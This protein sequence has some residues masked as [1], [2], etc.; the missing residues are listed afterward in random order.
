MESR[1]IGPNCLGILDTHSQVN[2]LFPSFELPEKG[3]VS[4][5]SQSGSLAIDL[6][7]ALQ[8]NKIGLKRFVSYGNGDDLHE[9]DFIQYFGQ[10]D[11]FVGFDVGP[12]ANVIFPSPCLHV[13]D[14]GL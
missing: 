4:L 12:Q 2:T 3:Q 10:V 8:Q 9:T 1:L 13:A 14:I 6:L 7:L 11:C 5:I